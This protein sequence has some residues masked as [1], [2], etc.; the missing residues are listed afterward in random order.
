MTGY[1]ALLRAV[2][3]AE[4]AFNPNAARLFQ[5]WL[6]SLEAQQLLIDFAAQHS[7]HAQAKEKPGRRK[8]SEIKLMKDDA[9][10]VERLSEEI[11]S[12]YMKIFRV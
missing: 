4:S 12:R 3:H 10:A 6:H 9:A 7:V 2:I 1:V 8:L 11:K 5:S